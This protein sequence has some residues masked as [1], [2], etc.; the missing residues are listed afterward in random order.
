MLQQHFYKML[1]TTYDF[2]AYIIRKIPKDVSTKPLQNPSKDLIR[3]LLQ[4]GLVK[5]LEHAHHNI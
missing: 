2:I 4:K 5:G 1:V 3:P